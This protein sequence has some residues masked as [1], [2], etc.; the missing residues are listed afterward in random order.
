MEQSP[1]ELGQGETIADTPG[2]RVT[3][4]LDTDEV[5]VTEFVY[6][7]GRQGA[8]PHVHR[9]HTDGF[10]VV[11]GELTLGIGDESRR[12]PAGTLVLIPP[13]VVHSFANDSSNTVRFLNFHMP[14]CG[15][16]DYLRGQNTEFDQHEPPQDRGVDPASVVTVHISG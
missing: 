11:A 2:R 5:A 14:S 16:G 1:V 13:N 7:A 3:L 9:L 15:F 6:G 10:L 4:L 8:Q 12:V